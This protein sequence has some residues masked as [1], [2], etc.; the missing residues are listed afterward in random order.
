MKDLV[1]PSVSERRS[2]S[3]DPLHTTVIRTLGLN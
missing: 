2:P 1:Q 3:G